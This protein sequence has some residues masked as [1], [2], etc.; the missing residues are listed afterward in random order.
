MMET[1]NRD[2]TSEDNPPSLG[3]QNP[4]SLFREQTGTQNPSIGLF[5]E[6]TTSN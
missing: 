2:Q 5:S 3:H 6:Q 4:N 1:T